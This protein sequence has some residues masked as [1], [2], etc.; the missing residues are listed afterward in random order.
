RSG[1]RSV[2]AATPSRTYVHGYDSR[3]NQRL[4][5]QAS[6]LVELLH[7]DTR[8][9]AGSRVLEAGCGVGAQTVIL[10]AGSPEA[11]ITSFDISEASVAQARKAVEAQGFRNVTLQQADIFDLPFPPASFDHLFVCFVLEHLAQPVRALQ[12]LQRMVRPGG[13]VTVIEGD[14]GSTYFHP[15]SEF[16]RRAVLCQVE[17]QAQAHGNALIGRELYPLLVQAGLDDVHVSP[18]MVYVDS[19]KPGLVDGFTRKTFT[20]MIEGVRQP[21]LEAGLMSEADFDRGVADLH[22]TAEADGVFCYTFFKARA[23]RR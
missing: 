6:T 22:R 16:A 21:A 15:D 20:A 17:L 4:Q 8:Y 2:T 3:E 23:V 10:A 19:S 11:L 12:A 7:S 1:V 13:T 14:H 18:R 5:D 9:P